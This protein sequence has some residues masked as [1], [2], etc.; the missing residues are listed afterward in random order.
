[1]DKEWAELTPDEKREERL[2]WWLAPPDVKFTSPEAEEGYWARLNRVVDAYKMKEPDRVPVSLPV[3][4]FPIQYAGSSLKTVMYDYDE[5]Y[6]VWKKYLDEFDMDSFMAPG[7]VLQGRVYD[8]LDYR[9]YRWPGHGL[10]DDAT[11]HQFVEGEYMKAD[12]YDA[13]IRNPS[14]YWMRTYMPRAFGLFEPFTTLQSFT[15]IWELP[16]MYF[17]PFMN[18]QLQATMQAIIDIGKELPQWLAVV[19]RLTTEAMQA[20]VP[21]AVLGGLAKAPFDTIGDTLRGT[22]GIM[23]DMYRQPDKLLEA[24]DVITEL[25]ID[26]TIKAVNASRGATAFFVL[27]KGADGFMSDKDFEKF[28]WPSLRKFMWALIEEGIIP[29]L[30][31]EGS[32]ETRLE[33][34][35]EFPKGA[36]AWLFDK[37]DMA[38]AKKVVGDK[39]CIQGNVPTSLL[40]TATPDDVTAYCRNLIE[41]CAPGGG[42]ILAGGV[43]LDMAKPECLRAM[44]EAAKEYGVYK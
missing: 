21:P 37:T 9:L 1:M 15:D 33:T 6:R 20:G 28:Y 43:S 34:C 27:H 22:Q 42:Y 4:N 16:A 11:G 5:L 13:L 31:A 3:A 25:S 2:N 24:I 40:T 30:F 12:E 19:G 41:T 7:M 35:N 23:F 8:T 10:P 38:Y 32:Y 36:V 26:S 39:C 14:D 18:P 29:V 17:L 44:M